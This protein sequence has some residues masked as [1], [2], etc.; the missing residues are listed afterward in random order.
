MVPAGQ[1]RRAWTKTCVT[2]KR[3]RKQ[4]HSHS[5]HEAFVRLAFLAGAAGAFR[6]FAPA[7]RVKTKLVSVDASL[8]NAHSP[9]VPVNPFNPS[10]CFIRF[11]IMKRH[12][13][14]RAV[15]AYT[16]AAGN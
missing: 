10:G 2:L 1:S 6:G 9:S 4:V 12:I 13:C 11:N 5:L 7:L 15:L 16:V 14:P 8:S 3:K